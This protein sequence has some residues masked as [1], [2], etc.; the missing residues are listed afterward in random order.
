MGSQDVLTCAKRASPCGHTKRNRMYFRHKAHTGNLG[1]ILRIDSHAAQQLQFDVLTTL[2][3]R[4]AQRESNPGQ[5]DCEN[6]LDTL[7]FLAT[8]EQ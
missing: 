6:I 4:S 3:K 2:F 5:N 8:T 7:S 1:I